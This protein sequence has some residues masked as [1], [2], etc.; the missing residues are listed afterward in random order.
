[1]DIYCHVRVAAVLLAIEPLLFRNLRLAG[2]PGYSARQQ[3]TTNC[4]L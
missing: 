3:P 1:M 2:A 4:G